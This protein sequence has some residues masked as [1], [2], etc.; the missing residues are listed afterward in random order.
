MSPIAQLRLTIKRWARKVKALL[1]N[2]TNKI[3]LRC[4]HYPAFINKIQR[5]I[6]TLSY[7]MIKASCSR[8]QMLIQRQPWQI[9]LN[10]RYY[11]VIYNSNCSLPTSRSISAITIWS[12]PRIW[13]SS[14]S[15]GQRSSRTINRWH[16][17][18]LLPCSS[19]WLHLSW[20]Y[21]MQRQ[22][23]MRRHLRQQTFTHKPLHFCFS[24]KLLLQ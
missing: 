17:L 11:W 3:R 1:N 9:C 12:I 15:R 24:L 4:L 2:N 20:F 19:L 21:K 13:T 23:C 10:C 16:L 22:Q 14:S 8:R 6:N 5:V 18:Q 7:M